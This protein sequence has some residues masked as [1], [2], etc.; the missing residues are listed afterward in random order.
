MGA[1]VGGGVAHGGFGLASKGVRGS[2]QSRQE[3]R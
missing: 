2:V 3:L 1:D